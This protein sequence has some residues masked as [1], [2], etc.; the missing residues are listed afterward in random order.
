M[1]ENKKEKTKENMGKINEITEKLIPIFR[2]K[3][4]LKNKGKESEE[5]IYER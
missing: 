2:D 4:K 5:D 3:E 1:S